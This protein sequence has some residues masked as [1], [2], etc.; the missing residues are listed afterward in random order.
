MSN[1]YFI[2]N[3]GDEII[4]SVHISK[5]IPNSR[6]TSPKYINFKVGV[7]TQTKTSTY[8]R[9]ID[10]V[11]FNSDNNILLK[12]SNYNLEI[13]QIAVVIPC[14]L[15]FELK[16][17][18]SVLPKPI[19]RKIDSSPVSERATISFERGKSVSS[20][21][22]DFPYN[23]SKIKGTFLAFD[24]LSFNSLKGIKNK[25][26]FINLFSQELL[27]KKQFSL[28]MNNSITKGIIKKQ[29]YFHNSAAIMDFDS[30]KDF[31]YIFY[32]KDTL[33]IPIFISYH[34]DLD[35]NLSLEHSHP[36]AEYFFGEN[37]FIGQQA[38]K[39]NWFSK[40]K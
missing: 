12:S 29:S 4:S 16:E 10:E 35:S 30:H 15:N 11:S 3:A 39:S 5:F 19:S 18:L 38:V 23:M 6:G 13:G 1:Y 32:S 34:E 26:I 36:P 9:K 33:G 28:H 31:P 17:K 37:K 40:L 24:A 25:L 14:D 7:Y 20:Y 2:V 22:G 8:W 21:Q 27:E